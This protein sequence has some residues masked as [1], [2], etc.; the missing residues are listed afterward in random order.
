MMTRVVVVVI[1]VVM[2]DADTSRVVIEL[3]YMKCL[4]LLLKL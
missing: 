4:L 1:V 2:N 3:L